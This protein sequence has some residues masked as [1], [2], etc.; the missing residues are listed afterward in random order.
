MKR[1]LVRVRGEW[2]T[3]ARDGE[4]RRQC[5]R[6]SVEEEGK[7]IDLI[8]KEESNKDILIKVII[9]PWFLALGRH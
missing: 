2:R 9:P 8:D 1:D 5:N 7:K 6:I 4:L 3:R